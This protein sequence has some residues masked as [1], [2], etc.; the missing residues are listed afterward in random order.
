[1]T[2]TMTGKQIMKTHAP[3]TFH[4][5]RTIKDTVSV[6]KRHNYVN[7]DEEHEENPHLEDFLVPHHTV[8]IEPKRHN[9][10][11]DDEDH[12]EN[13]H[14]ED[15]L[16]PHHTVHIEPELLVKPT[17]RRP[18]RGILQNS[19][20][21]SP[22]PSLHSCE[23]K[24]DD[25][26]RRVSFHQVVVRYYGMILGD[27]PNCSYGPPVTL[28]WDYL[29]YEP[30]SL[31]EYEYHHARRRPIRKLG[32]NYY[33]RREILSSRNYSLD[34]LKKA[35]REVDRI[36]RHRA[37]TRSMLPYRQLEFIIKTAGR[38]LKR[39]FKKEAPGYTWD[40]EYDLDCSRH[41]SVSVLK[42]S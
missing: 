25:N 34:E 7:D 26:N 33:R 29:E 31:D 42:R 19:D 28:E 10:V 41:S 20:C 16:V 4:Y 37:I 22:S 6:Q 8:H 36:K 9:Y 23:L 35:T 39:V 3:E 18:S 14:S 24:E 38:R 15:F 32:L 2:M 40:K 12:E 1:M 11:N 30:L 17:L 27:H 13:P 21:P 5:H